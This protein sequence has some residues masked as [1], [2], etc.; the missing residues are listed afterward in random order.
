MGIYDEKIAGAPQFVSYFGPMLDVLRDLGGEAA[1]SPLLHKPYSF[2]QGQGQDGSGSSCDSKPAVE[3]LGCVRRVPELLVRHMAVEGGRLDRGVSHELLDGGHA[4]AQLVLACGECAA[5]CMAG[6]IYARC[7]VNGLQ[8]RAQRHCAH[9]FAGAT[10]GDQRRCVGII[11]APHEESVDRFAELITQEHTAASIA[12]G[13]VLGEMNDLN[14]PAIKPA[15]IA[16]GRCCYFPN[17]HSTED[18]ECQC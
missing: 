18:A 16:N 9:V 14:S 8:S 11:A 10:A 3:A 7:A 17:T 1:P 13:L 6:R 5:S 12:L 2:V 15:Y 4:N